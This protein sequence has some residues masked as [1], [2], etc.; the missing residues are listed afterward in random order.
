MK[1]YDALKGLAE[2]VT[3]EDIVVTS[4][5][6][7]KFEW[8]SVRSGDG[9]MYTSLL[10]CATPFSLGVAMALPHRRVFAFDTDGS[11]LFNPGA[12]CTVA[13]ELPPNLTIVV[14]DNEQYEGA[15]AHPSPT[16]GT[17]DLERVAAGMGMPITATARDVERLI[18]I[19][20]EMAS[21]QEV[22]LVVAKLEPGQFTDF[23]PGHFKKTDGVEDTYSFIRHIERIE[24]I[25]IRPPY[26]RE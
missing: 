11:M 5:G 23:P 4:I 20:S 14:L 24:K 16:S 19:T 6:W 25:S 10:G 21:D 22:G 1:R 8:Y 18:E 12:L 13:C 3:D 15:G 7:I 26:V 17:V 2:I 9:T